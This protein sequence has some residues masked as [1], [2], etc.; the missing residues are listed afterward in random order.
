MMPNLHMKFHHNILDQT[1]QP[2]QSFARQTASPP[3]A[4]QESL[5]IGNNSSVPK[6]AYNE[7]AVAVS[8]IVMAMEQQLGRSVTADEVKAITSDIWEQWKRGLPS[9]YTHQHSD[10]VQPQPNPIP[11]QVSRKR[12]RVPQDGEQ[13]ASPAPSQPGQVHSYMGNV[14]APETE[15]EYVEWASN[16]ME[17]AVEMEAT[18]LHPILSYL[19]L[20]YPMPNEKWSRARLPDQL[21]T[22][23]PAWQLMLMYCLGASTMQMAARM[24]DPSLGAG[25]TQFKAAQMATKSRLRKRMDDWRKQHGGLCFRHAAPLVTKI[26]KAIFTGVFEEMHKEEVKE[27]HLRAALT[28]LQVMFNCVW[29]IDVIKGN[30]VQPAAKDQ[31]TKDTESYKGR[32]YCPLFKLRTMPPEIVSLMQTNDLELPDDA[33]L[34]TQFPQLFRGGLGVVEEGINICNTRSQSVPTPGCSTM[35]SSRSTTTPSVEEVHDSISSI[36]ELS[37]AEPRTKRGRKLRGHAEECVRA[38]TGMGLQETEDVGSKEPLG[39]RSDHEEED[40]L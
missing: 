4:S 27:R 14:M 11:T 8:Q 17:T 28:P 22:A 20:P 5:A 24:V 18:N 12:N 39:A 23:T 1:P 30:M 38:P 9:S 15:N 25:T 7:M 31:D 16:I 19:Y 34:R 29:S 36:E 10:G 32:A 2:H 35:R 6:E 26:S 13:E 3:A 33:N 40:D 21:D 37:P